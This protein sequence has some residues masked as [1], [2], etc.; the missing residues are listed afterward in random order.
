MGIEPK[1]PADWSGLHIAILGLGV[2]GFAIADTLVELG[3]TVVAIGQQVDPGRAQL[4]D[5]IGVVPQVVPDEEAEA[6]ALRS[7]APQLVITSPGYRPAHPAI[8]AAGEAGL[9]IWGEVDLAWTLR[10]WKTPEAKW[11]A[12]TGTNGKTSTV[13]LTTAMCRAGGLRAIACGNIGIPILDAI[14]D[15]QGWDVLVLELSS[16][17]LHY[18]QRLSPWASVCLNV[19]DDH[20]DWHGSAAAYRAAKAKVYARTRCACVFNRED[21]ATEQFVRDADVVEGA[22]AIGFGPGVPAPS[23][24][25]VV[26][27]VLVDRAFLDSRSEQ[28]LELVTMADL[29][30]VRLSAPH[31]VADV[32]AAA[33]LARSV[34]VAP[35][36]IRAGALSFHPDAHRIEP[37]LKRDGVEWIDDS[38]ATNPHAAQASLRAFPSVVWIVGGLLKGVDIAPLV[39][40]NADRVRAAVVIGAD[41]HPVLEA[42][43]RHAPQVPV[44]AVPDGDTEEIIAGAVRAAREHAQPGDVVLLAPAAASWDQFVSYGQRGDLFA[45]E[46]RAQLGGDADHDVD[47]VS[48]AGH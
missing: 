37:V 23:D 34:E 39:E 46:V 32:L 44:V 27:G 19:A 18:A 17:Q 36:A 1:G 3:A 22:R 26:D 9:P 21:P 25:G 33:A 13:E 10:S 6:A 45:A 48:S 2:S 41:E 31:L 40:H 15:P 29:Q 4:Y 20:I 28:A 24:L 38:K 43:A 30:S 7:A 14:R 8:V 12:V 16:F 11:L 47:G 5:A 42:F 35:A